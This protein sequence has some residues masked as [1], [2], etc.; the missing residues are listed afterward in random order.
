[1]NAVVHSPTGGGSILESGRA[2]GSLRTL[3][4]T[5][6]SKS[7]SR[8]EGPATCVTWGEVSR[9]FRARRSYCVLARDRPCTGTGSS[10]AHRHPRRSRISCGE[11]PWRGVGNVRSGD[12][13]WR[14]THKYRE[15]AAGPDAELIPETSHAPPLKS[16]FFAWRD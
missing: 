7:C 9:F 4:S 13:H 1:M 8:R 5:I 15:R 12:T 16:R 11:T 3:E 6:R 14:C 2:R 10:R